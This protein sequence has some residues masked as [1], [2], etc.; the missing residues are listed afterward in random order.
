MQNNN[1]PKE[2][3]IE[4]LK[5][6]YRYYVLNKPIITDYEYDL[7]EKKAILEDDQNYLN[8]PGSDLISSYPFFITNFFNSNLCS[9]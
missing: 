4:C 5:H 1:L 2:I 7:L 6:R 9:K 8:K 3:V